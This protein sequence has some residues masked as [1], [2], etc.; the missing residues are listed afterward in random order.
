MCLE[1]SVKTVSSTTLPGS[2][3]YTMEASPP[4]R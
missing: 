2:P 4:N 3:L 1:S